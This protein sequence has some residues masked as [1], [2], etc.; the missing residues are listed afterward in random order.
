MSKF[1]ELIKSFS[2]SREYVR[3]FFVYGFKTREEFHGWSSRTYDNERRRLESWLSGYVR[4]DYTEKGKNIHLSIDSSLQDVNPLYRVWKAKSFTDNDIMLHFYV[5][6]V[7]LESPGQT[8]DQIADI[9]LSKHNILF[10]AQMVR[11]KCNQY[12]AEGI[13]EKEKHG[14]KTHYRPGLPLRKLLSAYPALEHAIKLFQLSSPLGILGSSLMDNGSFSNN[15]F[16][17]KHNFFVHTLE[18]EM[19][20]PILQAMH[21][22]KAVSLHIKSAKSGKPSELEGAPLKI[23]TSTRTG[24]RYLCLYL[25]QAKRFANVR[26]DAIKAVKPKD[27]CPDYET[28]LKK[29][30]RNKHMAWGVSFQNNGRFRCEQVKLTF[31]IQSA[32]ETHILQR[33]RRE[34]KGGAIRQIA[35]DTYTYETTVFD[36][37][38]MLP[39]LRTFTVRILSAES[40]SG[41]LEQRFQKDFLTMYRMYFQE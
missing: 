13:L 27:S 3:D 19:L 1:S 2:K 35:P 31:Q 20:F 30:E 8:A 17:T 29:L 10:D 12:A 25:T 26:M 11:R 22:K 37:N 28:I 39:W 36:T 32:C 38:E 41:H 5:L 33:L 6:D 4:Q 9:I 34:G 16:L 24:R 40:D 21:E 14:R 15:L 18:D 23:F 7:L